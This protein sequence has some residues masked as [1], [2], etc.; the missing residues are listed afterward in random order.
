V[1]SGG[2]AF[3]S[4]KNSVENAEKI[5]HMAQILKMPAMDILDIGGGFSLN[6]FDPRHD[7]NLVAPKINDLLKEKMKGFL[8][9]VK[10][11][12]EPGRIISED[13]TTIFTRVI[14]AK[15]QG[16]YRHYYI[17]SGVYQGFAVRVYDG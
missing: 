8:K 17:N 5:F 3:S 12:A 2:C 14:L 1:G 7:F 4:Y 11:I 16:P 10:I 15:Q 6:P 9:T 13:C